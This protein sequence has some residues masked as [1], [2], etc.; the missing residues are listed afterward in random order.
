MSAATRNGRAIR[1]AVAIASD[2]VIKVHREVTHGAYLSLHLTHWTQAAL[3]LLRVL[4][5]HQVRAG[6]HCSIFW[7]I[8][9]LPLT[10]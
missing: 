6:E 5:Q 1:E 10:A 2:V 4:I 9:Y 8:H 3:I 7:Q